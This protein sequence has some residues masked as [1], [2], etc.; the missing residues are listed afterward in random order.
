MWLP[1]VL[2]A[3]VL[4][5]LTLAFALEK[6]STEQPIQELCGDGVQ[7]DIPHLDACARRIFLDSGCTVQGRLWADIALF[8]QS[9]QSPISMMRYHIQ[10]MYQ[11][12]MA[13]N[14]SDQLLCGAKRP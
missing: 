9:N 5:S 7:E 1:L 4:L 10:N 2:V 11:K 8:E 12:A 13:G 3:L 6:P 14:V